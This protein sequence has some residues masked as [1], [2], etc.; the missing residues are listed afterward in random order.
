MKRSRAESPVSEG[1][2]RYLLDGFVSDVGNIES[3]DNISDIFAYDTDIDP[4]YVPDDS[5]YQAGPS[6][7]VLGNTRLILN[8]PV[9][10]PCHPLAMSLGLGLLYRKLNL[11]EDL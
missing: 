10:P 11:G 2:L 7:C 4:D 8:R 6:R 3:E 9:R 5:I 1:T